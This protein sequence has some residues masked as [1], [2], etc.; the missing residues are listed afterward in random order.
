MSLFFLSA[1]TS[2]GQSPVRSWIAWIADA[3]STEPGATQHATVGRDRGGVVAQLVL[4]DLR[5]L[6]QERDLQ[7]LLGGL[8]GH[9]S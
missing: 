6:E 2:A 1:P 3:A 5:L 7:V 9:P 4:V 8:L